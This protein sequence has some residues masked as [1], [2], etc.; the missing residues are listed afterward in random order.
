MNFQSFFY[1]CIICFFYSCSSPKNGEKIA[2]IDIGGTSTTLSEI[3][4]DVSYLKL[5]TN[6][7]SLIGWIDNIQFIQ[8]KIFVLDKSSKKAVFVFSNSGK[9][10]F[11]IDQVNDLGFKFQF[12]TSV[13]LHPNQGS[14]FILD[15]NMFSIS[16]YKL[17]GTFIKERRVEKPPLHFIALDS[18]RFLFD[19]GETTFSKNRLHLVDRNFNT[20]KK[21]LKKV[22]NRRSL[23]AS[24]SLDRNFISYIPAM[25]NR[26]FSIDE[27][28]IGDSLML[29]F[30]LEWPDELE[31]QK[32]ISHKHPGWFEIFTKNYPWILIHLETREHLALA[33]KFEDIKSTFFINKK[34]MKS[35]GSRRYNDDLGLGNIVNIKGVDGDYFL[36]VLD[37]HDLLE[38]RAKYANNERLTEIIKALD[39][40]DNPVVMKFK[41]K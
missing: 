4:K 21:Y 15:P 12:P 41:L 36:S 1:T 20:L 31:I 27:N 34:N 23:G 39:T 25:S 11:K 29:D 8:D 18:N 7:S 5:E 32:I 28:G 3:I 6:D 26:I 2:K 9:F 13:Q 19:Y 40:E 30:G 35:I 16:E 17:N 38:N 33:F 24:M 22:S 10:L 37:P 14:I